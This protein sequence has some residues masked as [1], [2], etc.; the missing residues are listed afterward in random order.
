MGMGIRSRKYQLTG[1]GI[2]RLTYLEYK[3]NLTDGQWF[4]SRLL[5]D[6]EGGVDNNE[7]DLVFGSPRSEAATKAKLR[8]MVK[9]GLVRI[10]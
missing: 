1:L 2:E 6:I 10:A 3:Q 9:E 8:R 5:S 4:E 7:G